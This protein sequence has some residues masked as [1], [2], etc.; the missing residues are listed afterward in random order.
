MRLHI[1][2]IR[3]S[4]GA[5]E[6]AYIGADRAASIS[7]YDSAGAAGDLVELYSFLVPTRKREIPAADPVP[8]ASKKK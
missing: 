1:V 8:V 6:T 5:L 2:L 4:S 7:V 3:K